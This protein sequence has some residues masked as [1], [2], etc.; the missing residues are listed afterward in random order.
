MEEKSILD[1]AFLSDGM[2]ITLD[3]FKDES[4]VVIPRSL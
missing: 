2:K 3:Y 4:V 1:S